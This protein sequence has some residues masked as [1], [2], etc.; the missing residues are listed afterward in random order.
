MLTDNQIKRYLKYYK[1]NN[2]RLKNK[3]KSRLT[4]DYRRNSLKLLNKTIT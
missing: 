1:S 2:K 4:R 3:A